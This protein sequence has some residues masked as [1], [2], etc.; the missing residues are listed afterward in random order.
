MTRPTW[1]E[2]FMEVAELA[3]SRSTC[4]RAKVG[5]VLVIDKQI[6]ATGY[7][8]SPAG[9]PHC[10]DE[11]CYYDGDRCIRTI[12]AEVNAI[13]Q[14]ARR[15]ASTQGATAYVTHT[16]C[17]H[18]GKVLAS[19]GIKRVYARHRYGKHV[20]LLSELYGLEIIHE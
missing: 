20:S 10:L 7:N 19:A 8:G 15:G 4:T 11:G 13:G 1:N 9:M 18:C 3:A 6:I 16:P 2:Y 12:H 17:L 5:C 14:A